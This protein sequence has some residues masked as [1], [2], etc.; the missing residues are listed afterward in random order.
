MATP[1]SNAQMWKEFGAWLRAEDVSAY[2]GKATG[3]KEATAKTSSKRARD[4]MAKYG[5]KDV[6]GRS[7]GSKTPAKKI[8]ILGRSPGSA[9]TPAKKIDV[10][11]RSPIPPKKSVGGGRG[12]NPGNLGPTQPKAKPKGKVPRS[13][14]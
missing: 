12:T 2:M 3:A 14:Y 11:G 6:L 7:P 9:K 10:L 13:A 4:L 5:P 8:D 1:K